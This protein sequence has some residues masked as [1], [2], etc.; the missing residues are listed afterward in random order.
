MASYMANYA[1]SLAADEV[2]NRTLTVKIHTG[3]PGNAGTASVI[4]KSGSDVAVDVAANGW[5]AAVNGRVENQNA[6][7]FGVLS[8]TASIT[9]TDYSLWDGAN[10]VG[11][12]DLGSN[13]TVAANE[14]FSIDAATID[15][16]FSRA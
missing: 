8:T 6:V 7:A 2:A 5:K 4:Q 1:L 13:V 15:I 14:E 11:W 10:F 9:V 16:L 12:A 3:A